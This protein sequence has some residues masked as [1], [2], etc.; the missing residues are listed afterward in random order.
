MASP[1][2]VSDPPRVTPGPPPRSLRGSLT[3]EVSSLAAL[4]GLAGVATAQVMA[5]LVHH[6]SALLTGFADD[7]AGSSQAHQDRSFTAFGRGS[8]GACSRS[9]CQPRSRG[10]G[11]ATLAARPPNPPPPTPARRLVGV[12]RPKYES[13]VVSVVATDAPPP[14]RPHPFHQH[15]ESLA[16]PTERRNVMQNPTVLRG[17]GCGQIEG[18]LGVSKDQ[19][20]FRTSR[21]QFLAGS[22]AG[23]TRCGARSALTPI[24]LQRLKLGG[25]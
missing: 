16:A 25:Q 22:W 12:G 4:T 18:L 8:P 15:D 19:Q 21:R 23:P 17:L 2:G 11:V 7:L 13:V 9:R 6:R 1:S 5:F 10:H 14:D 24:P 20:R 3:T